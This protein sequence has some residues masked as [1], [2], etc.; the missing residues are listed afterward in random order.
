MR[1]LYDKKCLFY[2]NQTCLQYLLQNKLNIGYFT[3]NKLMD[4]FNIYFYGFAYMNKLV[5][6]S[7]LRKETWLNNWM[8][9]IT[10]HIWQ[11]RVILFEHVIKVWRGIVLKFCGMS[12]HA[13]FS[14]G[15][16]N[17]RRFQLLLVTVITTFFSYSYSNR[18][19]IFQLTDISV[20]VKVNLNHTGFSWL[21]CHFFWKKT[22]N[23]EIFIGIDKT[24][25]VERKESGRSHGICLI[26]GKFLFSRKILLRLLY[27]L[28]K[29]H[30]FKYI[31]CEDAKYLMPKIFVEKSGNLL[32]LV[33]TT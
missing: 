15:F 20:A 18:F 1:L 8:N 13:H 32:C 31:L 2:H 3:C 9:E 11:L 19:L 25:Q 4:I 22:G 17:F 12:V 30:S 26:R 14:F 27:L 10:I 5:N 24:G 21:C 7:L 16:L 6:Q 33:V 23:L 28:G 29:N